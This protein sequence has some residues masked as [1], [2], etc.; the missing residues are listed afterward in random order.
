MPCDPA[1]SG[2]G[3]WCVI[4]WRK[5]W[6]E[7]VR[8]AAAALGADSFQ[9]VLLL[10]LGVAG[11]GLGVGDLVDDKA[12]TALGDDVGDAVAD[13][14]VDDGLSAGEA[15][16][17]EDVD[18]GVGQPREH[19]QA[20]GRVEQ[21]TDVVILLRLGGLSETVDELVDDV[22]EEKHRA[23]PVGP[24]LAELG[25]VEQQLAGVANG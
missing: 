10:E 13:L 2:P 24:A 4:D 12:D 6:I 7:C 18:D 11:P 15:H 3:V 21:I 19:R 1:G 22:N 14:D 16:H 20:L 9:S 23:A 17:W 25:L 5:E 8:S